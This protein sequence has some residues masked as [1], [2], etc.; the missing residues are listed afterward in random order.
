MEK[1]FYTKLQKNY[2]QVTNLLNRP[3]MILCY[4]I[5]HWFN[6]VE[7]VFCRAPTTMQSQF[8]ISFKALNIYF[9]STINKVVYL[10]LPNGTFWKSLYCFCC[11]LAELSG[12]QSSFFTA[13]PYALLLP[14]ERNE[15]LNAQFSIHHKCC[16]A[17]PAF[18]ER[19][20]FYR[21]LYL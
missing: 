12:S 3:W 6:P 16:Y 13:Q 17:V 5:F 20:I 21:I 14:L 19:R 18:L 2:T 7:T 1:S 4:R 10:A 8:L 11:L 15:K 9:H